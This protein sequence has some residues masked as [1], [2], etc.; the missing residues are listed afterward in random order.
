MF[1]K[2]RVF[3]FP[4]SVFAVEDCLRVANAGPETIILDYFGG[5]GTTAHAVVNLN[6]SSQSNRR[7]ILIEAGHQFD[8]V[9]KPRVLKSVYAAEWDNGQPVSR[10][11]GVSHTI[12]YIRL[13]SY[14]DSLNN[15][16]FKRAD[17][18]GD[19][20]DAHV[21]LREDYLLRY[22]LDVETKDSAS[23]LDL[24]LFEDPFQYKLN[25]GTGTAGETRS[26]NVDL[27]ET[28]NWLLGLRVKHIDTIRG[29]RVVQGTNPGDEKVV[30]IWRNT[31]EKSNAD[32]DEFFLKQGY[33]TRD[34]EF[35]LIYVNG[36]N[37][38]ENLKRPDETWKVRL[39]EEEFKSLMFDVEDV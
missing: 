33:N 1:G 29:F 37:N 26:I 13:E 3:D 35:D 23:L 30:V 17:A 15:I 20:L 25:V 31:R 12:K 14:E 34:M 16:E 5:S 22:M 10:G 7:Y 36:D 18:Q 4:K 38:L 32:L 2:A 6:R 27:I 9:L 11:T 19:L 21:E 28:F 24:N 39:I 8:T